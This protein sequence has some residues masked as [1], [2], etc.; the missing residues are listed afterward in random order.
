M[1]IG[2]R[3]INRLVFV[4][5]TQGKKKIIIIILIR[6]MSLISLS[7]FWKI[8]GPCF[9]NKSASSS[10]NSLIEEDIVQDNKEIA[11]IFN[12]YFVNIVVNLI[13]PQ[14]KDLLYTDPLLLVLARFR[15]HPS[16]L[17][18]KNRIWNSGFS[19]QPFLRSEI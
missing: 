4:S 16:I 17:A 6:K 10:I 15:N 12:E 9:L 3:T 14:Y 18:I 19:F 13:I 2:L 5:C 8:I 7:Y 1:K 11:N